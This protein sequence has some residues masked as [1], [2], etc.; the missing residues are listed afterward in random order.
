MGGGPTRPGQHDP[1][2][3]AARERR[4]AWRAGPTAPSP[5]PPRLKSPADSRRVVSRIVTIRSRI[6]NAGDLLSAV[7]GER[8]RAEN[9]SEVARQDQSNQRGNYL[10]ELSEISVGDELMLTNGA[11][12]EPVVVGKVGK[13]CVYATHH[14]RGY[15]VVAVP[16]RFS[17]PHCFRGVSDD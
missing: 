12:A 7:S 5:Q 9:C 8:G 4:I 6:G 2:R 1:E 14:E 11:E 15:V 10:M 3:V 16:Q 17:R 13:R